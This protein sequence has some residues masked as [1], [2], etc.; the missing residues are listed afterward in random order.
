MHFEA[1]YSKLNHIVIDVVEAME[2]KNVFS[3]WFGEDVQ[4]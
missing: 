3:V 1:V 2:C 4:L